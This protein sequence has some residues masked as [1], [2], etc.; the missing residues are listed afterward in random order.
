MLEHE[1]KSVCVCSDISQDKDLFSPELLSSMH[2]EIK[3]R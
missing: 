3:L 2:E 1:L